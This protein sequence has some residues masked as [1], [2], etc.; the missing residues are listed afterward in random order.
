MTSLYLLQPKE[1][2]MQI[3]NTKHILVDLANVKNH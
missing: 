1:T 3:V 2:D